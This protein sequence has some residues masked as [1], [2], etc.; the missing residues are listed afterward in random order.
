[1]DLC[2]VNTTRS[3][4]TADDRRGLSRTRAWFSALD[5]LRTLYPSPTQ[6][7][8]DRTWQQVG[9]TA[10]GIGFFSV[11]MRVFSSRTDLNGTQLDDRCVNDFAWLFP[12]T[13][14]TLLP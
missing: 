4:R 8:F 11:W 9:R 7:D 2:G 14:V 12:G 10:G 3:S 13:D 5:A 1:M 6:A